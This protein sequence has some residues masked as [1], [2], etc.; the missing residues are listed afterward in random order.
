MIETAGE[1]IRRM[2]DE[3][4]KLNSWYIPI[5]VDDKYISDVELVEK[6]GSIEMKIKTE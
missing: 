5:S 3:L 1:L 2:K 6:D 4:N